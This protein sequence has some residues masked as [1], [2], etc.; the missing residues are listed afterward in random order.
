MAHSLYDIS[1][2]QELIEQGYTLLTPNFRLARRIKA[3]WDAVQ[4]A[5]GRRVWE[6]VAVQ[7]LDAWLLLQW[8]RAVRAN[9]VPPVTPLSSHQTLEVWRQVISNQQSEANEFQLLRPSAAAELAAQARDTLLRWQVDLRARNIRPLFEMDAD[10]STFLRWSAAFEQRLRENRQCTQVDCLALL[11]ELE[12]CP[13]VNRV[14][15]V[16]IDQLTPLQE[17]ALQTLCVDIRHMLPD[18]RGEQRLLHTFTDKRAELQAVSRWAADLHR[19]QPEATIGIVLSDMAGDRVSLE[20]LLRREFDCLGRNYAS[21]PVNFSTGI[22]LDQAPLVRDALTAL[23]MGLRQTTL[24][25][26]ENLMRSRFVDL[27]DARGAVA[28]R[29]IRRLYAQGRAE[30]AIPD[31]RNEAQAVQLGEVKGLSLGRCLD[32]L[33]AMPGLRRKALPSV[34]ATRFSEILGIWGWPGAQTLDSLEFQQLTLWQDT[35]EAF[36]AFDTVSEP[37]P[38]R[39]ALTLLRDCCRRQVSQPQTADSTV[40]VLGPLEAAGL[41]F[42][43]LW[44]C[45]MQGTRWPASPSPN[46][47]IPVVL[48]RQKHMP[49]A[50]PEREWAFSASLLEQ[51]TRANRIIHASYC[52]E[53]DGV[54]EPPSALLQDFTL[55]PI[56]APASIP[57]Q[58]L[59]RHSRRSMQALPD[60]RAAGLNPDLPS[61]MTGGSGLLEDQ[62]QC[63]FRAFA[64]HRLQVEPLGEFSVALS[65]GERGALLH[66]ALNS[67]WGELRDSETL[68]AL[69]DGAQ[70]QVV[71]NAARA[72]I[73]SIPRQQQRKLSG[74]YWRLEQLRIIAL[75]H[76]WLGVERQRSAFVVAERELEITLELA[77]LRVRLRLDRI[78]QL[79]DGSRVIIDYKSG[80]CSVQDWLGD[81]PAQP[82]LLLYSMIEPDTLAGLAFASVRARECRFIGLGRADI[83][84]G[85]KE[86]LARILDSATGVTEWP[87]LHQYWKSTLERL[88]HEFVNGHAPVDPVTAASCT[89]CGLQALCRIDES[90]EAAPE[91]SA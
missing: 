18:S 24:T 71:E 49:H 11:P 27:L 62:S 40:Q 30:V 54:P 89:W 34:W 29:L 39:D 22:N 9:L 35:L 19:T 16:E 2:L 56:T 4:A 7:P 74:A 8:E 66:E 75:L 68:F 51:Y 67:L 5:S 87:Q 26:V 38:L 15:L 79:S 59:E 90:V 12:G 43:Q 81:R 65:A 20:Y 31:L 72:A 61:A 32:T 73:A 13:P 44:V 25:D 6:A 63:P 70:A 91:T 58:W 36:A 37:M 78:D 85:I 84:P 21:L 77:Q 1:P 53:V 76:E 3:E 10:C 46:P 52:R 82:Q 69:D 28:Q 88:A 80:R 17:A 41:S 47:F 50:D 48:Q 33:L 55:D 86:D 42:D 60:D 83:A 45:G 64:R 14:A 57:D 23:A